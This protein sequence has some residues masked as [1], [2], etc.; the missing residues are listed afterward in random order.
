[1]VEKES[2]RSACLATEAHTDRRRS[3]EA[4][5]G[6]HR[7]R[8]RRAVPSDPWQP[9]RQAPRSAADIRRHRWA[10]SLFATL[11]D[12]HRVQRGQLTSA[13]LPTTGRCRRPRPDR[14]P[15]VGLVGDPA[16]TTKAITDMVTKLG[17]TS[18]ADTFAGP[19]KSIT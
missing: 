13:A 19:I 2:S 4:P 10:S 9:T 7:D 3:R 12:G 14:A 15:I 18:A 16:T 1:M 8:R 17:P 5:Q 11:K 6:A